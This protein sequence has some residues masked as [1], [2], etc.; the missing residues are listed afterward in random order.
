M[1]TRF[2]ALVPAVALAAVAPL[3][4]PV[5]ET[6][7]KHQGPVFVMATTGARAVVADEAGQRLGIAQEHV[8]DRSSGKVQFIAVQTDQG[9]GRARLVPYD[10]FS[11]DAKQRKLLLPLE[12]AELEKLPEY[13]PES[14]QS[15]GGVAASSTGAAK[16]GSGADGGSH[17]AGM[18]ATQDLRNL[19]SS[20]VVGSQVMAASGPFASIDGMLLDPERGTIAFVLARGARAGGDPYLIPWKAMRY[21]VSEDEEGSFAL[22]MSAE[23]LAQAP[24]LEGG[25]PSSLEQDGKLEEILAF[26]DLGSPTKGRSGS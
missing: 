10:R 24:K 26:Y 18:P 6:P 2:T 23:S 12:A 19:A 25:D 21:E 15:L 9:Q 14:L 7:G 20:E 3:L 22:P 11:W 8:I 4:Q 5:Q 1:R 13:D 17:E 16:A